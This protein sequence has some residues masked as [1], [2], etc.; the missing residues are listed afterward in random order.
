[1]G[2]TTT[3]SIHILY[4]GFLIVFYQL[5]VRDTVEKGFLNKLKRGTNETEKMNHV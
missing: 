1:M 2:S 3:A 5:N 4:Y